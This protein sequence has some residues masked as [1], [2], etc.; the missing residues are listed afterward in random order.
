MEPTLKIGSIVL[1]GLNPNYTPHLA[2]IVAFHPPAGADP[3]SPMCGNQNQGAGDP[4]AC[5]QSTEKE[6]TQTFIKR[7]VGDPGD[8][9]RI[10]DGH[11][12][13]NGT[14]ESDTYTY[15]CGQAPSCNFPTPIKIPQGDY[16]LLGD[17]RGESDDSRFWGPVPRGWIVGKVIQR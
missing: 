3:A 6:S 14:R 4:Q 2:D 5:D 11:V 10:L 13:R 16:F 12:Y 9:I 8:V 7:V 17:N 15:A 1:V